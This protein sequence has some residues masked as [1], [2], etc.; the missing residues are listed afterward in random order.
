MIL[1]FAGP[2]FVCVD[3]FSFGAATRYVQVNKEQVFSSSQRKLLFGSFE[4]IYFEIVAE[5]SEHRP[6]DNFVNV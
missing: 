4:D 1:D 6:V 5:S 2:N 3:N